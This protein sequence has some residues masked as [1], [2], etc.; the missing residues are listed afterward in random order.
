MTNTGTLVG[1]LKTVNNAWNTT[2]QSAGVIQNNQWAHVVMTYTS[3]SNKLYI[4]GIP[5]GNYTTFTGD[6]SYVAGQQ[7]WL[8]AYSF[9]GGGAYLQ[10]QLDDVRIYNY[11]LTA[12]QVVNLYNNGAVVRFA[13]NTGSP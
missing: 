9:S 5:D 11:A 4:N 1:V 2:V 7:T 13:P 12:S 10:G 3:G 6:I 8:G